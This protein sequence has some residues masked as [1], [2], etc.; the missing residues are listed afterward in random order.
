MRK[1]P[2]S[3]D[4]DRNKTNLVILVFRCRP[5]N[6]KDALFKSFRAA[7]KNKSDLTINSYRNSPEG[8]HLNKAIGA[9]VFLPDNARLVCMLR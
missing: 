8:R 5:R 4:I 9:E 3:Q 1:S 2:I 6:F 7:Y